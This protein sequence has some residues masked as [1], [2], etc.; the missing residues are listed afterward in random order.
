MKREIVLDIETKNT[1]ADV[2][3]FHPE[4]LRISLIGVYFYDTDTYEYF[5]E[6]DFPKL[7][8]RL[9]QADRIIGYNQK[10]FDNPVMNN[11]YAGDVNNVPQLDLLEKIHESLGYRIKLDDVAMATLGT[12]KTGHGLQAVEYWKEGKIDELAAYCLVDVK[13]TKGVYEFAQENGFVKYKDR[14]GNVIEIPI[15]VGFGDDDGGAA[16]NLTMPF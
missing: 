6:E 8:Q 2:G 1:F 13:V 16:I 11:Y 10:H 4:K 9:E 15:D 3:G 14:L 5:L 7:W 12:G